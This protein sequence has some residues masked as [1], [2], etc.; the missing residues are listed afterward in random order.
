MYLYMYIVVGDYISSPRPYNKL[1]AHVFLGAGSAHPVST[2]WGSGV[3]SLVDASLSQAG[4]SRLATV[5][6]C[7]G[8]NNGKY[9]G[10]TLLIIATLSYASNMP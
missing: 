4:G 2:Q 10:S 8:F 7:A 9:Y 5:S 6:Y 1:C 3:A